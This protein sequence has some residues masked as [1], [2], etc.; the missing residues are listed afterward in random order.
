MHLPPPSFIHIHPAPPTSIQLLRNNLN[1]IRIK[2]LHV[3]GQFPQIKAKKFKFVCL[4]WKL[5]HMMSTLILIF[6]PIM[7][8]WQIWAKKFKVAL[9]AE[10]LAHMVSRGYWFLFR[11][12]F[13]E[14]PTLN[15]FLGKFRMKK[16][17]LFVFA[18][19]LAHMV[20]WRCWFRIRTYIFEI[21]TPQFIFFEIPT[22][23][24]IIW[25]SLDQKSIFWFMFVPVFLGHSV[26]FW[27]I[28]GFWVWCPFTTHSKDLRKFDPFSHL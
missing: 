5:A 6:N 20:S 10:K 14:F 9:F 15:P 7:I 22:P 18:W 28:L 27:Q 8:F 23:K 24:F 3:I 11:H 16:S 1:I 2:I 19:K 21:L 12:W 26:T 17:K 4:D 25:G 13:S